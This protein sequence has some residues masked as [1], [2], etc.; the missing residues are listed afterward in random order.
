M[1]FA[2]NTQK[3]G[4]TDVKG[5][6]KEQ[7]RDGKIS[8]KEIDLKKTHLNYDLVQSELNLYQ[9]VKQRVDEVR[10]V[11]RVQ[12]NSVVDYSNIITVP[13]DQF[14]TWGAEKSKEYLKE[15][16]NYF[17]EEFGKEN[18][19]SAKVHLDETTPHMHLHFVPVSEEGKLQARKVMTPK[20]INEI[21]SKAPKYLQEKGFDVVRGVGKTDKS[22]EINEYK[23]KKVQEKIDSLENELNTLTATHKNSLEELR[24]LEEKTRNKLNATLKA[25]ESLSKLEEHTKSVLGK[26]D[27]IE[28]KK[29]LFSGKLT[30]SEQD[31]SKL[32]SLAQLGES[33]V[34][35]NSQLK[36]KVKEMQH[37]LDDKG[38]DEE[39]TKAKLERL[40]DV[41]YK[42]L[43]LQKRYRNLNNGFEVVEKALDRLDL[44][45]TVNKEMKAIRM[46]ERSKRMSFDMER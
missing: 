10:P 40:N 33:K 20:H 1:E 41:E 25:S 43:D 32:I 30:I 17:C 6:E 38:L 24:Q 11:S 19:V 29:T 9:R 44:T 21:H 8:N 2:W 45:D 5:L 14:K 22:L 16:Y 37:K 4:I 31:Y 36:L 26:L 42:Y 18:V 12:K 35:E 7:E 3:N 13:Q 28:A 39:I 46:A 15:V 27:S 34:F 23:A